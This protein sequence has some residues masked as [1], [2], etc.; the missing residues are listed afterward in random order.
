MG[1]KGFIIQISQ[2]SLDEWMDIETWCSQNYLTKSNYLPFPVCMQS[3][4]GSDPRD[5]SSC[6]YRNVCGGYT[7]ESNIKEYY[8]FY[9]YKYAAHDSHFKYQR[10]FRRD[11]FRYMVPSKELPGIIKFI[12]ASVEIEE[13]HMEHVLLSWVNV[14]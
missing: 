3:V 13:H 14:W 10:A 5:R 8:V 4:P 12:L 7:K 1:F 11:I 6:I 2:K 9:F